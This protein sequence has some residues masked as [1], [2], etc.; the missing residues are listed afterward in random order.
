[1]GP[2]NIAI[3]YSEFMDSGP[4]IHNKESCSTCSATDRCSRTRTA[5]CP[6]S[7]KESVSTNSHFVFDSG[8]N[9]LELNNHSVTDSERIYDGLAK[10]LDRY[11]R[12]NGE[13][14]ANHPKKREKTDIQ[15]T[16]AVWHHS[17]IV[18]VRQQAEQR[19]V[20]PPRG[21]ADARWCVT[22]VDAIA[23]NAVSHG[24]ESEGDEV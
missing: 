11:I 1:V 14:L 22:P 19:W 13:T 18:V 16:L 15:K 3:F 2:P 12:G 10:S 23:E 8:K 4:L 17:S 6:L 24:V 5:K 21:A 7:S 20:A 9:H